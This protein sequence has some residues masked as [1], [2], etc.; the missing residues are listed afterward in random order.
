MLK[1]L[2]ENSGS[3]LSELA[4]GQSRAWE[5]A[6]LLQKLPLSTSQEFVRQ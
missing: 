2:A 4:E 1:T 6:G 3:G 5:P